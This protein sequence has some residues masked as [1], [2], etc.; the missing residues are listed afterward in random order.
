MQ[1]SHQQSS[2]TRDEIV[3]DLLLEIV[4]HIEDRDNLDIY[5]G[6][7]GF[8]DLINEFKDYYYGKD[9]NE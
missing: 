7:R 2:R 4:R 3:D 8:V 5:H 6:D 1:F 9:N